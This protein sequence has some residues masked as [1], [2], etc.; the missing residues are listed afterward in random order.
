MVGPPFLFYCG[1]SLSEELSST[2]QSLH[3]GACLQFLNRSHNIYMKSSACSSSVFFLLVSLWAAL[4]NIP[5]AVSGENV[6]QI[7]K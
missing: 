6:L 5:S 1:I 3:R 7:H 2:C 4:L